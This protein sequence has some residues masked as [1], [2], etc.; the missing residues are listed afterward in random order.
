[1]SMAEEEEVLGKRKSRGVLGLT[2][3][4]MFS[5]ANPAGFQ[6]IQHLASQLL[7]I[8]RGFILAA[9]SKRFRRVG[10]LRFALKLL[11]KKNHLQ[12]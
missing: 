9:L 4:H 11:G 1:M 7:S 3:F 2:C 12:D 8:L 10:D 5:L 6:N